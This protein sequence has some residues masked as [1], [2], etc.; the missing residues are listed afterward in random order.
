[1][2][3]ERDYSIDTEI[4]F[5]PMKLIDIPKLI[6]GCQKDWQNMSLSRVNDCVIRLGVIKGE[7][8]WH[9]HDDEDEFFYVIDGLLYIDLEGRTEK[10]TQGQGLLVPKRVNHRT[11]APERTSILMVEGSTVTPTGD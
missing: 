7:F 8:H 5:S 3:P 10:L 1:M 11:R 4:R 2:S 6:A 9:K